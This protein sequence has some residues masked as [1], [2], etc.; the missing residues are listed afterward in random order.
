VTI[1]RSMSGIIVTERGVADMRGKSNS[2]R[3]SALIEICHP[4]HRNELIN[5]VNQKRTL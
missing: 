1:P 2:E 3:A 4:D 5:S